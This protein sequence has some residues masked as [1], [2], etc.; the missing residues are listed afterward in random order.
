MTVFQAAAWV[1]ECRKVYKQLMAG[2]RVDHDR[3]IP[4]L[5]EGWDFQSVDGPRAHEPLGI[6]RAPHLAFLAGIPDD[7]MPGTAIWKAGMNAAEIES[8]LYKQC[9]IIPDACDD[10]ADWNSQDPFQMFADHDYEPERAW[11]FEVLTGHSPREVALF[12][13]EKSQRDPEVGRLLIAKDLKAAI[14]RDPRLLSENWPDCV[15]RNWDS[16]RARH[17]Q[18]PI[19]VLSQYNE[20]AALAMNDRGMIGLSYDI[21]GEP[22]TNV[23]YRDSIASTAIEFVAGRLE[24]AVPRD[25]LPPADQ[26]L[27]MVPFQ[28][29]ALLPPTA[30]FD[31]K[32]ALAGRGW[33]RGAA[34]LMATVIG[35]FGT[36]FVEN[37]MRPT[38]GYDAGQL[39]RNVLAH[40]HAWG[41]KREGHGTSMV[42]RPAANLWGL[43][44]R[45]NVAVRLL[46]IALGPG[47]RLGAPLPR[48]LTWRALANAIQMVCCLWLENEAPQAID[49]V[50]AEI[51]S[52]AKNKS[53]NRTIFDCDT[54]DDICRL[55]DIGSGLL[56][57]ARKE[58]T[59]RPSPGTEGYSARGMSH[60]WYCDLDDD[61]DCYKEYQVQAF[62]DDLK[63][64]RGEINFP[65]GGRATGRCTYPPSARMTLNEEAAYCARDYAMMVTSHGLDPMRAFFAIK[66]RK[67]IEHEPRPS[68]SD[69]AS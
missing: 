20:I 40:P 28:T 42:K 46:E 39:C 63:A 68:I 47:Y 11:V 52:G 49:H 33:S 56:K 37:L 58:L 31:E 51:R 66:P 61:V 35:Q 9:R 38:S 62:A 10:D 48:G 15:Q 14:A 18:P 19:H 67:P 23:K 32:D 60:F 50:E 7:K 26:L 65:F 53:G 27:Q 24:R 34:S 59:K 43:D 5:R 3:I 2:I 12:L 69:K 54:W 6:F 36:Q 13:S 29:T 16:S 41:V 57:R 25:P 4:L 1:A 44:R 17:A 55:P 8:A 64:R 22:F 45:L 30:I 21:N